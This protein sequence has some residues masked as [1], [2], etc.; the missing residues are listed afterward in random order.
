MHGESQLIS[1]KSK[2]Q[3][4]AELLK[5][6]PADGDQLVDRFFLCWTNK[7]KPSASK[8]T[9]KDADVMLRVLGQD[10]ARHKGLNEKTEKGVYHWFEQLKW[11]RQIR[12]MRLESAQDDLSRFKLEVSKLQDKI[13][14]CEEEIEDVLR[15]LHES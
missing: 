6:R 2:A 7:T 9:V 12:E 3:I 1:C 8:L 10:P 14:Q 4:R 5:L 15:G 11:N 13:V